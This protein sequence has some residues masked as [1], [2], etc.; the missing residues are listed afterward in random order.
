MNYGDNPRYDYN[1]PSK[2]NE[3]EL[4]EKLEP[5]KIDEFKN[6]LS[7]VDEKLHEQFGPPRR[8]ERLRFNKINDFISDMADCKALAMVIYYE[9]ITKNMINFVK[10]S[11]H[12]KTGED[13]LAEIKFTFGDKLKLPW[14]RRMNLFDY[15]FDVEYKKRDQSKCVDMTME[16]RKANTI[17]KY[18]MIIRSDKLI[19]KEEQNDPSDSNDLR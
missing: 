12:E 7:D 1:N 8:P 16:F 10:V 3:K 4:I 18:R 5:E 9:N 14:M 11:A 17:A 15:P 6:F 2:N 19:K 13:T